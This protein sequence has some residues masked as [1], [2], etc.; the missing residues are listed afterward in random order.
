MSVGTSGVEWGDFLMA[1]I[2]SAKV[3]LITAEVLAYRLQSASEEMLSVLV[4]T[5]FSPNIKERRDCSTGIFDERGRLLALS[6]IAPIHLSSMLGIMENLTKTFTLDAICEGDIFLTND[7]YRGGGSHLPD[8]TLLT[9][10][11]YK[12]KVAAFV[13]NIAHHSD[14]GGKVAGSESADCTSIFQEGLRIPLVKIISKGELQEAIHEFILLNSRTPRERWGDL[15]AQFAASTTGVQ[16]LSET[17]KRFGEQTFAAGVEVILDYA[18]RRAKAA[19]LR[20]PDGE[21]EGEDFLDNDGIVDRL[22]RLKAKVVVRG[23]RLHIDFTGTAPQIPGSRNMPLTA[24][25]STVYYAVKALVDP[26]LP[27][28]A[29]YF[30][31]I[32]ITAP[33]GT[34]VNCS[35]PAA[36]GDRVS[37]ANILG[38]AIFN[39][40]AKAIPDRVAAACGPLHGLIFSGV[41]PNRG[42]YFVDYE[43]YAGASGAM[44]DQDGRDAVRVHVSGAANL[45]VEAVEHEFPL[46][47]KCYELMTDTGGAGRFR[48]GLGTRREIAVFAK[49]ARLVGRGLRQ[50]QGAPGLFGG[51]SGSTGGFFHIRGEENNETTLP[52]TFSEL[53]FEEGDK[54]R[55]E[56]PAGGGYGNP[57]QRDT[58]LVLADLVAEKVSIKKA[59]QDYGVVV[60]NGLLDEEATTALRARMREEDHAQGG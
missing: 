18:E 32:D 1:D 47:V 25:L 60:K 43:T 52:A 2:S 44:N 20:I 51:K 5:A 13:A 39:A 33:P 54:I 27:P 11:F 26:E 53:P 7:P 10:V 21:Y 8:L 12:G 37:C 38:D 30:R 15:Q 34:V 9:P 23:D 49:E 14:I 46:V 35:E 3:D 28:N 56:T 55:V 50:K 57:M 29:G 6:A 31:A 16:R 24:T 42:E 40:F 59:R 45:P 36:V 4:K 19:I 41:N 58:E 22:I 48:G 17:F